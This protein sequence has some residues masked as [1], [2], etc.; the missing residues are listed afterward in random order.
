MD[1]PVLKK[2]WPSVEDYLSIHNKRDYDLAVNMLN[3]LLDE[4]GDNEKHPLY[5]FLE[6]LGIVIENYETEHYELDGASGVDALKYLM[7]EHNLHQDDLPEIGSQGVVSEILNGKRRLNIG[8]IQK[9]GARFKVS[10]AVF[11]DNK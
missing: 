1:A 5:S 2:S 6:V 3:R 4:V 8:Q 11:L 9:L 10:P 7:Q